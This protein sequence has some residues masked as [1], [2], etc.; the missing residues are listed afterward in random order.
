MVL[1]II[2]SFTLVETLK[3]RFWDNSEIYIVRGNFPPYRGPKARVQ[4]R[5]NNNSRSAS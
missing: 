3:L 2:Y 4:V 5:M 1:T